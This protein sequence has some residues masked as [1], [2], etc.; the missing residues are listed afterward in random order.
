MGVLIWHALHATNFTH[1]MQTAL[2]G[3]VRS[4]SSLSA[5]NPFTL[6]SRL[7]S[8]LL[9]LLSIPGFCRSS[10]I[11][12]S[13]QRE[14]L[15]TTAP[16]VIP[17]PIPSRQLP[18]GSAT[19]HLLTTMLTWQKPQKKLVARLTTLSHKTPALRKQALNTLVITAHLHRQT[20]AL[21]GA[22][23]P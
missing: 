18:Q 6:L 9:P 17:M 12:L 14:R 22:T 8:L 5:Q 7:L 20:R 13:G 3:E 21:M 15:T 10:W 4:S 16:S 11:P 1:T 2:S 19:H 23:R